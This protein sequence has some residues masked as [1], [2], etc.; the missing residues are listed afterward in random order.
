M[1]EIGAFA[2]KTHFSKILAEVSAGEEIIITKRRVKIAVLTPLAPDHNVNKTDKKTMKKI[3]SS[4]VAKENFADFMLHS[5]LAAA[6][7]DLHRDKSL[8]REITL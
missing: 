6:K 1:K 8:T 3:I 7:L 2:A 5:P 4:A